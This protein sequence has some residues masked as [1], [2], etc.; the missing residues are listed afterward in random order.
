MPRSISAAVRWPCSARNAASSRCSTG[1]SARAWN[2]SASSAGGAACRAAVDAWS[3]R[4]ANAHS[5]RSMSVVTLCG[6]P[7]STSWTACASRS[8][9]A[10]RR[11]NPSA[12]KPAAAAGTV[13]GMI[14]GTARSIVTTCA[15]R[16]CPSPVTG[17]ARRARSWSPR[18]ATT[19]AGGGRARE[20]QRDERGHPV[21]E[22]D[23]QDGPGERQGPRQRRT[24][25]RQRGLVREQLADDDRRTRLHDV[26]DGGHGLAADR[27]AQHRGDVDER[28]VA[29]DP[30]R[31]GALPSGRRACRWRARRAMRADHPERRQP[32]R[33]DRAGQ[34]LGQTGVEVHAQARPALTAA[35]GRAW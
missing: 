16:A 25:G 34:P 27:V 17:S 29:R 19:L 26:E 11:A 12:R 31:R 21:A 14:G 28:P 13:R 4:V 6:S 1:G 8:G 24:G 5:S 33:R 2:R 9:P 10:T 18:A 23:P 7:R 32:H 15:S 30:E 35:P 22:Q 20:G 3:S